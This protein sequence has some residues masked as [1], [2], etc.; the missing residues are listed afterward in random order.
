MRI[1]FTVTKGQL[2]TP[3]EEQGTDS[4]LYMFIG[5]HLCH[6]PIRKDGYQ[7]GYSL[8]ASASIR[9]ERCVGREA[10][11]YELSHKY[12]RYHLDEY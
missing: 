9:N 7:A 5:T 3:G 12:V 6:Q 11:T 1:P 2:Y 4:L 10:N 8:V